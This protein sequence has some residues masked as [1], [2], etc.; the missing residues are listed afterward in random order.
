MGEQSLVHRFKTKQQS[1][2]R[3]GANK[4][5][6]CENQKHAKEITGLKKDMCYCKIKQFTTKCQTVFEVENLA[7]PILI[8]MSKQHKP[9]YNKNL[10]TVTKQT[11]S[12]DIT[13]YSSKKTENDLY[14]TAYFVVLVLAFQ[15]FECKMGPSS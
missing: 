5:D 10:D 4:K 3:K 1:S 9:Q 12:I 15:F 2:I 7:S 13:N 14:P 8:A 6:F 11:E